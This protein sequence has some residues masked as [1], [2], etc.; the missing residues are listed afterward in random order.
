MGERR[1]VL[2]TRHHERPADLGGR[3]RSCDPAEPG[4]A[5]PGKTSP[6]GQPAGTGKRGPRH[7]R[8]RCRRG[9]RGRAQL[10]SAEIRETV[11][12]GILAWTYIEPNMR[13]I[14]LLCGMLLFPALKA[15]NHLTTTATQRYFN[16]V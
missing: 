4:R 5:G 8:Y 2:R 14:V 7:C 13:N 9:L 10:A 11:A 15:Q 12:P 3:R 1:R 6:A 16:V